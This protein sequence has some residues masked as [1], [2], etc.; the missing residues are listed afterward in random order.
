MG[1]SGCHFSSE[2]SNGRCLEGAGTCCRQH[3]P[4]WPGS[5]I[6]PR[7]VR[8]GEADGTG[9]APDMGLLQGTRDGAAGKGI[10]MLWGCARASA[11]SLSVPDRLST[12]LK[13]H[14]TPCA[15]SSGLT[16]QL[17]KSRL[18]PNPCSPEQGRAWER[19]PA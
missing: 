8:G 6:S 4:R 3:P 11:G 18:L 2:S 9:L 12:L 10:A 17:S 1:G 7:F 5:G 13:H 14:V 15:F 16:S 19:P